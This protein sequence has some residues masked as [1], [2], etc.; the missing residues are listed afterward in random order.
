MLL[1]TLHF[2]LSSSQSNK[3]KSPDKHQRLLQLSSTFGYT[4]EIIRYINFMSESKS[5]HL[6]S[7]LHFNGY[8]NKV[9]DSCRVHQF[10][11]EN[12]DNKTKTD[13]VG[14]LIE[15]P[16][17]FDSIFLDYHHL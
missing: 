16:L 10:I 8:I 9:R 7:S 3:T 12:K 13:F 6:N 14:I 4:D 2:S 1:N 17:R 5:M 15:Q 11:H